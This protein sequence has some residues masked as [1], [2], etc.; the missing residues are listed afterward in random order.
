VSCPRDGSMFDEAVLERRHGVRWASNRHG[1]EPGPTGGD[2]NSPG[3]VPRHPAR[4]RLA[5]ARL[6]FSK[7]AG[8][9][10]TMWPACPFCYEMVSNRP[11][12]DRISLRR[13]VRCMRVTLKSIRAIMLGLGSHN[14]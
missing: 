9:R 10:S 14:D 3:H 13:I 5:R 6:I 1:T 8:A 11:A 12:M 2:R 7:P 4:H